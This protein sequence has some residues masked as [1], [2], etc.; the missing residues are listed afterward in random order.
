MRTVQS[1]WDRFVETRGVAFYSGQRQAPPAN[2][3]IDT[4]ADLELIDILL[5]S[6]E[7]TLHE[8]HA[9]FEVETG[10]SVHISTFCQAVRRVGFSRTKV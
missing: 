5:D 8:H 7:A 4:R 3:V 6:P 2:R 9:K 1:I 10:L